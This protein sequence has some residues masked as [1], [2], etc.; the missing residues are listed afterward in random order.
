MLF[1]KKHTEFR[2]GFDAENITQVAATHPVYFAQALR[3]PWKELIV[4]F[5]MSIVCP[6]GGVES[7]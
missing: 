3:Q 6:G 5:P 1:L 4:R 7:I 2:W